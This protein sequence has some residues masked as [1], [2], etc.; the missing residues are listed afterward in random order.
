M[1]RIIIIRHGETDHSLENR[2]SGFSDPPLNDKG[3]WQAERLAYRMRNEKVDVAY[4]SGL[5]RAY[6][7]AKIVFKNK[8]IEKLANFS[9]MNFGIFEGLT[10]E[11]IIKKH[12]R[13]Y[14][15]WIGNPIEV[16][17]LEIN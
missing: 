17:A 11:E 16:K 9:E 14:K 3:I 10:Y 15:S 13:L 2:Y 12:S 1:A 8:V 5:K 7:T 6:E 4:S